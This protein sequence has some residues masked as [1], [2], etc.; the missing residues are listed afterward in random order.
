VVNINLSVAD[1][2]HNLLHARRS[3]HF[4]RQ[5]EV[6]IL[7]G[8]ACFGD[9][10]AHG[11][12]REGVVLIDSLTEMGWQGLLMVSHWQRIGEDLN[13]RWARFISRSPSSLFCVPKYKQYSLEVGT[14]RTIRTIA[15]GKVVVAFWHR[16]GCRILPISIVCM[17]K[18]EICAWT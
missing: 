14:Q 2:H 15:H 6:Q 12:G 8:C 1:L 7:C 17:E 5:L 10:R 13:V 4:Q 9:N 18:N 11:K 16:R 3:S